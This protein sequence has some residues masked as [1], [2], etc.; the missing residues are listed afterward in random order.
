MLRDQ[1]VEETIIHFLAQLTPQRAI[2]PLHCVRR[3]P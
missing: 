2:L 3:R 1:N